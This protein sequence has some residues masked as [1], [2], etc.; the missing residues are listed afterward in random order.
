MKPAAS[1]ARSSIPGNRQGGTVAILDALAEV[2][3]TEVLDTEEEETEAERM[4]MLSGM[5][6]TD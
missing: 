3:E 5:V 2:W 6:N 1:K 4:V